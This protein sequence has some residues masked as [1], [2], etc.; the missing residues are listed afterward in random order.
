VANKIGHVEGS[1]GIK[2]GG[3]SEGEVEL[4]WPLQIDP[5]VRLTR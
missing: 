2:E 1:C 5:L 4:H 3:E